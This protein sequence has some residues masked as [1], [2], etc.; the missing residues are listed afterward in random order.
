MED[1]RATWL[2]APHSPS[3]DAQRSQA[4]LTTSNLFMDAD[5]VPPSVSL[6]LASWAQRSRGLP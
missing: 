5:W 6:P 3:L 4:S 1:A 2:P